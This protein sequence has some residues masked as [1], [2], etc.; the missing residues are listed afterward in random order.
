MSMSTDSAQQVFQM[1]FWL[2]FS[3][4][5]CATLNVITSESLHRL[6]FI[7]YEVL[8]I[9]PVLIMVADPHFKNRV[10]SFLWEGSAIVQ[11]FCNW[12]LTMEAQAQP[13]ASP[14]GV[15]DKLALGH[16]FS[17]YF[18]CLLSV[19]FYQFSTFVH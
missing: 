7:C 4:P 5:L 15:G 8:N 12:P 17:L 2:R 6:Q 9:V 14:H 13:H 19:S 3:T 1:Q 18:G 11:T 10:I 16:V